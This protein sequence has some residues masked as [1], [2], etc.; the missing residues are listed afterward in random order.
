MRHAC[1]RPVR[2]GWGFVCIGD[3]EL[4]WVHLFT[5]FN[6]L[7]IGIIFWFFSHALIIN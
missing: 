7:I 4:N 2:L 3:R 1:S 5:F 6:V